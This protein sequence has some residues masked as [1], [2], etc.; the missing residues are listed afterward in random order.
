MYKKAHPTNTQKPVGELLEGL[1]GFFEPVA[2]PVKSPSP[3]EILSDS[4]YKSPTERE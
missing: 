1:K 3:T 4:G 2:R